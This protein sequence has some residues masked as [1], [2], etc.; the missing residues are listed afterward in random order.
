MTP[1]RGHAAIAAVVGR[2][3]GSR[4]H[5]LEPVH[6]GDICA[7]Y[8]VRL[9]DGRTVFTKTRPGSPPTF[10]AV[11]GAGLVRL[12]AVEGGVPVPAVIGVDTDCLVLD[13]VKPGRPT[14]RAAQHVGRALART[15]RAGAEVFGSADGDIWIADLILPGGPWHTWEELWAD[16]RIRPFLRSAVDRRSIGPSDAHDVERVLAALPRL[17]GPAE[18]PSL[19][20]G[21]LWA[22]NVLWGADGIAR[23]VDPAVHGG[24]RE[25]DLAMLALFGLPFL[26]EVFAAYHEEW[27]LTSGWQARVALHQLHPV[28]VHA[29]LFGGAY[30][31]QAGRLARAV[32]SSR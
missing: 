10:F 24:H 27:P 14:A 7:A 26:A 25:T 30:G 13:W 32:L 19:I 31:A 12:G 6:G 17:A 2:L 20:H 29:V 5:S 9:A 18:P 28:L 16:G 15:H 1:E 11:E 3:A 23:V 4:V 21:D 22:G 8:R